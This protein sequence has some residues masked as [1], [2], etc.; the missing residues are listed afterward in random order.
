MLY[1]F[2][3]PLIALNDI[4]EKRAARTNLEGR[5]TEKGHSEQKEERPRQREELELKAGHFRFPISEL[6]D[7]CYSWTIVRHWPH[8]AQG[9]ASSNLLLSTGSNIFVQ[10]FGWPTSAFCCGK[11]FLSF[12]R[13]SSMVNKPL[14][15]GVNN[16]ISKIVQRTPSLNEGTISAACT[17]FG[18]EIHFMHICKYCLHIY[19]FIFIFLIFHLFYCCTP[20]SC[21]Q[22]FVFFLSKTMT[23]KIYSILF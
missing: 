10:N 8:S 1:H 7:S 4:F 18:Y 11:Q 21:L 19:I 3:V 9:G 12:R 14:C 2:I 13:S 16:S 5:D 23:V 20:T 17:W 22:T 15:L 6:Y